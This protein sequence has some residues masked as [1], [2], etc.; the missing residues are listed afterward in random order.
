MEENPANSR[1]Y[2]QLK[3]IGWIVSIIG[4]LLY[5][6]GYFFDGG[7]TL[8]DWPRYLPDWAVEFV[9]NWEAEL[10]FAL[11][12]VGSIPLYYVEYKKI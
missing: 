5:I 12:I 3:V 11:S 9:P 10:G 8:F 7:S 1:L 4:T 6:Y 2:G